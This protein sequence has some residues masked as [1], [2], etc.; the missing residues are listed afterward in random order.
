[1]ANT[2]PDEDSPSDN[3]EGSV[4]EEKE[5]VED[6]SD[7]DNNVDEYGCASQEHPRGNSNAESDPRKIEGHTEVENGGKDESRESKPKRN[8][9]EKLPASIRVASRDRVPIQSNF[10]PAIPGYGM[11]FPMQGFAPHCQVPQFP[12]ANGNVLD[13]S[14]TGQNPLTPCGYTDAS[15]IRDPAP[16]TRRNR[17]GVTEP[18]PQKLHRM[19]EATEKEGDSDVVGWFSHGRAFAIHKAS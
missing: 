11:M 15:T 16:D 19:L 12:A 8:G 10:F 6:E 7:A 13:L 17:G 9:K 3:N 5:D 2:K 4:E 1:M 18:F 14:L